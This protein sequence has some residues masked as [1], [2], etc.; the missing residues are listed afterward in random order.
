MRAAERPEPA[1]TI[2]VTGAV[3]STSDGRNPF[4]YAAS[5]S[6]MRKG[7]RGRIGVEVRLTA[8]H[9]SSRI[10]ISPAAATVRTCWPS[11]TRR[12]LSETRRER[13]CRRERVYEA[14]TTTGAS[15]SLY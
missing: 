1:R 2:W 10:A 5:P 15:Q 6:G 7:H 11:R 8:L 13:R 14:L 4:H 9:P 3:R 12:G